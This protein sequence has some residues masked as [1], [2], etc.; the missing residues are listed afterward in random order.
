MGNTAFTWPQLDIQSFNRLIMVIFQSTWPQ[1]D[2][3]ITMISLLNDWI[4]SCSQVN[5]VLPILFVSSYSYIIK[6]EQIHMQLLLNC[7][8][9]AF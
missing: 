8:L 5:A 6:L 1:L 4:S 9:A 7:Y 3:N 2:W